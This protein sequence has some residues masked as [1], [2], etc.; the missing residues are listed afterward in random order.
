MNINLVRLYG[1]LIQAATLLDNLHLELRESCVGVV[2]MGRS[3]ISTGLMG[4]SQSSL[5]HRDIYLLQRRVLCIQ[6]RKLNFGNRD[7]VVMHVHRHSIIMHP[8]P[9]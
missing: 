2:E 1:I 4:P 5:R 7:I 9:V 3:E 6:V 8:I